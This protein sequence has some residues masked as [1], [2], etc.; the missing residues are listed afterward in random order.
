MSGIAPEVVIQEPTPSEHPIGIV[1]TTVEETTP[2]PEGEPSSIDPSI[3]TIPQ[4]T[5]LTRT[6]TGSS[7]KNGEAPEPTE[8]SG[9]QA[10]RQY[11]NETN[12][13]EETYT[14]PPTLLGHHGMES[15][16]SSKSIAS[17]LHETPA[18]GVSQKEDIA[19]DVRGTDEDPSSTSTDGTH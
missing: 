2:S 14:T 1:E 4:N 19:I 15:R 11:I 16:N 18:V 5:E 6:S 7:E 10:L 12:K 9:E 17:V 13:D 8:V 3:D